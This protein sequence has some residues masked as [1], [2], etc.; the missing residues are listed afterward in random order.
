MS[1]KKT[2]RLAGPVIA[3]AAALLLSA[4][5]PSA[6]EPQIDWQPPGFALADATGETFRYPHDLDGPTIVLFWANW[7]PYCKALMP[8]LQSIVEESG[9]TIEVLALNFRDDSDP[10]EFMAEY[11]YDF[12]LFPAGDAVAEAWGIK[13]TPGLFLVDAK[14]RAVFSIHAIPE[15]A[16]SRSPAALVEQMK[17]YQRAARRSPVWASE[18]RKAIDRTLL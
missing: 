3:A 10:V 13:G 8:H 5:E 17:H 9:G 12:R 15:E 11:G 2:L 18:L 4:C 1:I 14:G 16:Y 6:P 7:C